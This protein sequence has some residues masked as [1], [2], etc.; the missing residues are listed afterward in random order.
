RIVKAMRNLRSGAVLLVLILS[1]CP[2]GAALTE[3]EHFDRELEAHGVSVAYSDAGLEA[4]IEMVRSDLA[5][6]RTQSQAADGD[7]REELETMAGAVNGALEKFAAIA[8]SGDEAAKAA[9]FPA[10]KSMLYSLRSELQGQRKAGKLSGVFGVLGNLSLKLPYL[11]PEERSRPLTEAEAKLEAANLQDPATGKTY[12]DPAQLAG[13]TSEQVSRLDVRSDSFLWYTGDELQKLKTRHGTAWTALEERVESRVSRALDA[14]YSLDRARRVLV[15]E[16]IRKKATS[17]KIDARDLYGIRWKVKWGE[18]VQTEA[19]ANHLYVELGGKYADPLYTNKGGPRD[20]V[21]VLQEQD[22]GDADEPCKQIA[23]LDQL[24]SC[25]LKS[26]YHFDVST[27]VAGH[28]VI[29]EKV[30]QEE[31]FA[32]LAIKKKTLLGRE[33]V[34]FNESQVSLEPEAGE[35][36]SL[37]AGPMSSAGALEDRVKRGL[38]VLSYWI[39]NKDVKDDNNRGIIDRHSST[40]VEYMHDMGASLGTLKISGNPNLLKIGDAYVRRRGGKV[41][42]TANVLYLPKAFDH[43]TYAD[44]VWMARKIID[45]PL[46]DILAAVAATRWPDF[47]QQVMASRLVARRNAISRAFDVGSPLSYRIE[48]QVVPLSTPA[49]RRAAV[50]RYQ[51][52]IAT[53]GDEGKALALLDQFMRQCGI[54]ID[55]RGQARYEDKVDVWIDP[56]KDEHQEAVLATQD[57]DKSVIVALLEETIHP[58]G[59]ARRIWRGKDDK[60]LE[61]CRPTPKTLGLPSLKD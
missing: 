1:S 21:L 10:I 23:S 11:S 30:L 26:T 55:G 48:P 39:Q 40:Y 61:A 29:T 25:L 38:A 46:Q 35:I 7:D 15:F 59:L 32:S 6:L 20:L 37:G 22:H 41:K 49:D 3:I 5:G 28:G 44:A 36:Q 13:L 53:Q 12:R 51:L 57:C 50:A 16:R 42:F 60:P 14:P 58:A 33:F 4:L 24:K 18:E 43:V 27:H 2:A 8:A 52:A 47:Q 17:P 54:P 19:L 9:S 45:L 34:T 31:P 56:R